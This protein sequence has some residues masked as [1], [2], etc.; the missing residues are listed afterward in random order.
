L[1]NALESMTA[2]A[3]RPVGKVSMLDAE[4]R[5]ML[6]ED[7]GRAKRTVPVEECLHEWFERRAA[8][9]PEAVALADDERTM[10]YGELNARANQ[11]AAHLRERGVGPD[12][13]VGLGLERGMAQVIAILGVLK[14]GGAYLPLDPS[15]PAERMAYILE[16]AQTGLLITED[17]LAD[18]FAGFG[19]EIILIDAQWE[20]IARHDG[21]NAPSGAQPGNLAYVIYT[22]GSTGNPKGALI[23]HRNVVRLLRATEPWYQFGPGDVWPLFHSYA[24]DVSVWE[25]WGALCY[26]GRLVMV[27]YWVSRAPEEFYRLLVKHRVT[28]LNQ[29]PSAF[30]QLIRGEEEAGQ[31]PD[32]A[33][34]VVVFAG[35]K[36]ELQSLR[37]WIERH[38]DQ[39]PR[40]INMYGIT[41]T[42]VHVTYRP[43]TMNEVRE[44]T[45]SMIG[46]AI[47]DLD[48]YILDEELQ[49]TPVGVPGELFVGGPGLGRGYWNRPELTAARFIADPYGREPGARLYR[50]GDQAR[51][52]PDGDIEYIGRVDLQ[53]QIRGFRV[54]MG[55]IEAA[56][57]KQPGVR[58]AVVIA[59]EESPGEYRLIA[60]VVGDGGSVLAVGDLRQGLKTLIPDYMIPQAFVMLERLPLTVNGKVDR[61]A[62][63]A[64]EAA[65]PEETPYVEPAGET[66][67]HIAAIWREVLGVPR[68]GRDDDFFE[69]GGHSLLAT[70]AISR[71]REQF[72][73]E[74]PLRSLFESPTVRGQAECVETLRW[75]LAGQAATAGDREEIEI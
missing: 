53:V 65:R 75:S 73:V 48:L 28:V 11:L 33:L 16:D 66:E 60:Y 7:W 10:S 52:T 67:T 63:P 8:A 64:P 27:P 35:E 55:E 4:E 43:I 9:A 46:G 42:T 49:P 56:L 51:H 14:A 25:I 59:R 21:A 23:E 71:V 30:R 20:A 18:R 32:L 6:I 19:G 15:S 29:T 57:C 68:I 45:A 61:R 44:G 38:G 74:L 72:Q 62:L 41:E 50:S 26:G 3:S 34:R 54:E 5:R 24:F 2:D 22:S 13:R 1:R 12:K 40:L 47:P 69:L 17:A 70:Q 58:E 37:P 31:S 36:L 39:T